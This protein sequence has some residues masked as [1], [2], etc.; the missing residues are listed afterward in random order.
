MSAL[1]WIKQQLSGILGRDAEQRARRYL[2]SQGLQYIQG[3]YRCKAGEIDL[4]MRENQ[5]LVFVEVKYRTKQTHGNAA[6]YFDMHKRR[7]FEAALQH[8]LCANQL[9]PASIAHRID[10]VAIDGQQIQ[11]IKYV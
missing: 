7:K 2:E 1:Q 9:N 5:E 8:Y 4:I 11:W 10:V 6:E 3:N